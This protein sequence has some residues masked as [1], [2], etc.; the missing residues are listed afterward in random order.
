M[1][2]RIRCAVVA[3]MLTPA[4]GT[5]QDLDAGLTAFDAGDYA[6]ALQEWRPLAEQG[7]ATAQ[8]NLGLMY[9][10]G[11]GVPQDYT[12]A[13]RWYRVAAEQGDATAQAILA[14]T[15]DMGRGVP[16]DYAEAL[17]W[18]RMSAERGDANAQYIIAVM[19]EN[20]RGVLQDYETAHMWFNIAGANGNSQASNYRDK[21]SKRMSA[22]DISEAQSR[23]RVCISSGYQDCD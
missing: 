2:K 5:A 18:Y 15:Y 16:Q 4:I 19:Y 13:L 7:D 22:A 3:L 6:T 8:V 1:I 10:N 12:E 23:A 21:L 9:E 17:R 20:G 14:V 11:K